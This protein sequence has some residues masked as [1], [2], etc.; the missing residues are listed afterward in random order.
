M[1]APIRGYLWIATYPVI[2]L[3]CKLPARKP[4]IHLRS[5]YVLTTEI[6][7]RQISTGDNWS[8]GMLLCT[9]FLY[10]LGVEYFIW[11]GATRVI[12]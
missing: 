1:T 7:D 10:A 9:Q 12:F 6:T 3:K 11:L 8:H 4:I 5:I 2:L